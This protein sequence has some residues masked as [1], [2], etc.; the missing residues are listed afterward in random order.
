MTTDEKKVIHGAE[1]LHVHEYITDE[2]EARG[3]D[4]AELASRMGGDAA[5]NFLALE[6][7]ELEDPRMTLG[8]DIADGLSRALGSSAALWMR[9]DESWRTHPKTIEKA[10]KV[11]QHDH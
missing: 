7:C 6:L 1:A 5:V 2:M 11:N 4:R 10:K 9:L 3:W 8:Q